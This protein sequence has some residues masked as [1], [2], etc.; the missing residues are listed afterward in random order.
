MTR[1]PVSLFRAPYRFE[2]VSQ[3][4]AS[5]D[6]EDLGHCRF[7]GEVSE[8]RSVERCHWGAVDMVLCIAVMQRIQIAFAC[9]WVQRESIPSASKQ[10]QILVQLAF[11]E[12]GEID[13]MRHAVHDQIAACCLFTHQQKYAKVLY[14][15]LDKT[16]PRAVGPRTMMISPLFFSLVSSNSTILGGAVAL[17]CARHDC[18]R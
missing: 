16:M 17:I 18:V 8:V 5:F 3:A 12:G 14:E 15:P 10:S 7:P 1:R 2:Y 13:H 4:F 6:L 11:E 9:P